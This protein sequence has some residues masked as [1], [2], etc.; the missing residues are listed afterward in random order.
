MPPL[1]R[2]LALL[3]VCLLA[4]GCD[5]DESLLGE[6]EGRIDVDRSARL[7][8][9]EAVYTILDGPRGPEFVL[10]LFVGDLFESDIEDYDYVL[11]RRPG[12]RPGVGAYAVDADPAYAV[13]A[14][15]AN[16]DEADDPLKAR[17][18]VLRGLEGTLALT[19]IDDYGFVAGTFQFDAAGF[20]VQRPAQ[21]V[22]GAASGT[23]EARYEPPATFRAL[24]LDL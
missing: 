1:P 2:V 23:F 4:A 15:I 13:A 3:A 21:A 10:G 24:G 9:G 11:F 17:G 7:V 12:A 20:F 5:A 18:E 8:E 6:F 14:T 19:R 22:T 16:V